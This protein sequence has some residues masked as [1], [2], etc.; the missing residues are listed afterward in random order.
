MFWNA[1]AFNQNIPDWSTASITSCQEMFFNANIFNGTLT[2]WVTTA[3][4]NTRLMF[5]NCPN[6]NQPLSHF[7]MNG[8]GDASAMFSTTSTFNQDI[9][10]W[11]ITTFTDIS[12]F[13]ANLN[14]TN[15]DLLLD[16]STGWASQTAPSGLTVSFTGATYTQTSVDSGTTDGTTASKLIDSTQ[17]FL[18]TVSINDIVHNT[19]DD[20]Y[21]E[22][23]AVDSDTSLSLDNDIM[24]SGETYVIQSSNAAKGRYVLLNTY[25]WT[26]NDGGPV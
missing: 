24:I 20:T 3:L 10:G 21:A 23:T 4:T 1:D 11:D 26:I 9:S 19:T 25:N 14:T 7:D 12:L 16:I 6:F 13:G 5:G 8:V 2:N 15:Y 22:V 18:T 17:N